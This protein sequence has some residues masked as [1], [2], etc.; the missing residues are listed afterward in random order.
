M[1]IANQP[2]KIE[3]ISQNVKMIL[4]THKIVYAHNFHSECKEFALC[5]FV[6]VVGVVCVCL[7]CGEYFRIALKQW[8]RM[9]FLILNV[10]W[11]SCNT[12]S[13]TRSISLLNIK[14]KKYMLCTTI[15]IQFQWF[16]GL[17]RGWNRRMHTHTHTYNINKRRPFEIIKN[18]IDAPFN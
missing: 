6:V 12:C 10:M 8:E 4:A 1:K 17:F 11:L 2:T 7:F 16:G 14:K 3:T 18:T 5:Q 13:F 9:T 15:G